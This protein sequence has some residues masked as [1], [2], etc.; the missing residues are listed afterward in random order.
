MPRRS[1]AKQRPIN[2]APALRRTESEAARS[3]RLEQIV[4]F[5]WKPGQSGNP[6]G[7][8]KGRL[9]SEDLR[10]LLKYGVP[11]A[12]QKDV[13]ALLGV[14]PAQLKGLRIQELV[15]AVL[16]RQAVVDG[17]RGAMQEIYDRLDPKP[18]R[19]EI[20]GRDGTP[21]RATL[22]AAKM[23]EEEAA[24]GYRALLEGD[25]EGTGD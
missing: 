16:V 5:Q 7:R 19:I 25:D 15:A 4:P 14:K 11:E 22:L 12:W 24:S 6:A 8:K 3:E 20:S 2:D 23:T 10:T 18:K 1:T 9:L 21:V 13:A 17:E